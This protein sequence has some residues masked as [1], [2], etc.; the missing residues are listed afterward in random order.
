MP[1]PRAA[2]HGGLD[3]VDLLAA[4][5][6]AFARVGIQARDRDARPGGRRGETRPSSRSSSTRSASEPRRPRADPG[7]GGA[8]RGSSPAP[9]ADARPRA[10]SARA[11]TPAAS[12]SASV[13]P[14]CSMPAR[15]HAS[16]WIG[17][18]TRP[19][20]T[21][22]AARRAP[23]Q[24]PARARRRRPPRRSAR[25]WA[26]GS[27]AGPGDQRLT[28][29]S[30]AA[31]SAGSATWGGSAARRD[32]AAGRAPPPAR[33]RPPP[34]RPPPARARRGRPPRAA[35]PV[36][37]SASQQAQHDL[38][39]DAG[40]V[41]EGEGQERAGHRALRRA[42]RRGSAS[43]AAVQRGV[44]RQ[45]QA[46]RA[47]SR[48]GPERRRI[49]QAGGRR[50]QGAR[51]VQGVGAEGGGQGGGVARARG[52][53]AAAGRPGRSAAATWPVPSRGAL[54][55][56]HRR[57]TRIAGG[58]RHVLAGQEGAE[59]ARS[60]DGSV[61]VTRTGAGVAAA[62][63]GSSTQALAVGRAHDAA[64]GRA[65]EARPS[66]RGRT[67]RPARTR[68]PGPAT[69]TTPARRG[70]AP[71]RGCGRAPSGPRRGRAP[72]RRARAAARRPGAAPRGAARRRRGGPRD[73]D[74]A[75]PRAGGAGAVGRASPAS[76]GGVEGGA[77]PGARRRARE[78]AAGAAPGWRAPA[79]APRGGRERSSMRAMA[80]RLA[81]AVLRDALRVA[82]QDRRELGRAVDGPVPPARG[83]LHEPLEQELV[84]VAAQAQRRQRDARR[85]HPLHERREHGATRVLLAVGEEDHVTN[86]RVSFS[87]TDVARDESAEDVGVAVRPAA[88]A[89]RQPRLPMPPDGR[90]RDVERRLVGERHD[91]DAVRGRQR[92]GGAAR[93]LDGHRSACLRPACSRCGR[94]TSMRLIGSASSGRRSA[95]R[96]GVVVFLRR[97]DAVGG[98][99]SGV[100]CRR[101]SAA[102]A[103]GAAGA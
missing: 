44:E 14:G 33:R 23:S 87:S 54:E 62:A 2:A 11:R 76:S 84:V 58:Q 47:A 53:R 64:G 51:P 69:P 9:S 95:R 93:A 34:G 71:T 86:R 70:A 18:V 73:R 15:R 35:G 7:P 26:A 36:G 40:R 4:E 82:R 81:L 52:A 48:D 91:G 29:R 83:E 31:A 89:S 10:A 8:A 102:A 5:E 67:A 96:P 28:G 65:V 57:R 6:T 77:A 72:R 50:E 60:P 39:A 98:G 38:G 78:V 59:V 1:R 32:G 49:R 94:C 92:R 101:W 85:G 25:G 21:P 79:A 27:R 45:E 100:G 42:G 56:D 19:S 97:L 3:H 99:W 75:S 13:C 20:T 80:S 66:A 17:P 43:R 16:L 74:R 22:A 41:A 55:A 103:E 24:D 61:Q 88:S 46:G 37:R 90:G 12:R 63:A 30:H 68:A